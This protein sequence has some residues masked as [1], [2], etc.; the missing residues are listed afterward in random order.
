[1][2]SPLGGWCPGCTS[3]DSHFTGIGNSIRV[4]RGL[5][6]EAS[7]LFHSI[8][9]DRRHAVHEAQGS[10]VCRAI[11]GEQLAFRQIHP[12]DLL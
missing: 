3:Y 2:L 7:H 11:A 4:N 8:S 9:R 10:Y 12:V 5:G 6:G 1:L